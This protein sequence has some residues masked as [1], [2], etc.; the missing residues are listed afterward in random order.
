MIVDFYSITIKRVDGS[1]IRSDY[2][3]SE[4]E[5]AINNTISYA[6]YKNML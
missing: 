4:R 5:S 6:L 2:K 1:I 3:D